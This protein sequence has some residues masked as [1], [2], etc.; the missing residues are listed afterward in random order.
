MKIYSSKNDSITSVKA[1][2][3]DAVDGLLSGTA[4]NY[5]YKLD[6][7]LAIFVGWSDGFDPS[8]DDVIHGP[9]DP[10]YGMVAGIKVWTSDDMWTDYD[11]LNYPYMMNGTIY[12]YDYPIVESTDYADLTKRLLADYNTMT[13]EFAEFGLHMDKYGELQ[14]N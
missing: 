9:Y 13:K 8:D 5:R 4:T 10:T 2:I 1:F 3:K 14:S 6:D 12:D 7:R 11:Y